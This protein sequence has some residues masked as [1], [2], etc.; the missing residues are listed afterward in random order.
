MGGYGFLAVL[1]TDV[2]VGSDVLAPLVLGMSAI[3]ILSI[4]R[5][6]HWVQQ[7]I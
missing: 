7:D 1:G 4:P 6:W 3:A 5:S 2:P